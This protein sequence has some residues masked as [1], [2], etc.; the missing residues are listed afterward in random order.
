LSGFRKQSNS[1]QNEKRKLQTGDTLCPS[2]LFPHAL[3]YIMLDTYLY[4][5]FRT[6]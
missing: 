4:S 3:Y 1:K 2:P 5:A 6:V